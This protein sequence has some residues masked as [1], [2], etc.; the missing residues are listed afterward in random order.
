MPTQT[1][2]DS[3][4]RTTWLHWHG[5]S[6]TVLINYTCWSLSYV[7]VNELAGGSMLCMSGHAKRIP[8]ARH[9]LLSV[10]RSLPCHTIVRLTIVQK[11]SCRACCQR[12]QLESSS[13]SLS[14]SFKPAV[15]FGSS[16]L[17]TLS[18]KYTSA[19]TS[20][21]F[22]ICS[23]GVMVS[24]RSGLPQLILSTMRNEVMHAEI[25]LALPGTPLYVTC[26]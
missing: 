26:T 20:C 8:E 5:L 2:S 18:L 21:K 16:Y 15:Q 24:G 10:T 9:I 12:I 7:T 6:F 23:F 1:C 14:L 11:V 17:F 25:L 22:W 4:S 19:W 13:L 3:S